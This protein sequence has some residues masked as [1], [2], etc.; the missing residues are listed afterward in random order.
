MMRTVALLGLTTIAG[1]GSV[2]AQ[3]PVPPAAQYGPW[4]TTGAVGL[5]GLLLWRIVTVTLPAQQ[6]HTAELVDKLG[7]RFDATQDR[8]HDDTINL[9]ETIREN[10]ASVYELATHCSECRQTPGS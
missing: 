10:T 9:A 6:K 4:A 7:A 5:L 2:L 3:A 8:Q 1:A